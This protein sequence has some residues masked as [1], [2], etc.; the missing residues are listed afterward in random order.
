[1]S[2]TAAALYLE[3]QLC[4]PL[5]AASRM[6]TKIY[7]PLL[8]ALGLTYPQYLVMLVLWQHGEQTVNAIGSRLYLESNTLTP[9]LKRLEQKGLITRRRSSKDER[10]VLVELTE[11]GAQL[12]DKAQEIPKTIIESFNDSRLTEPEVLQFQKTL[13]KLVE[14]LSER[15]ERD[16]R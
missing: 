6:T 13:F 16:Q 7:A 9:L 5:Y 12:K 11:P 15:A 4:F 1:M 14:I 2:D 10:S 3:N 8:K